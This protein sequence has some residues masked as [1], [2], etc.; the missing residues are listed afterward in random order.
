MKRFY[1]HDSYKPITD[2]YDSYGEHESNE[3]KIMFPERKYKG[4]KWYHVA[5]MFAVLFGILIYGI[6]NPM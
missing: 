3:Y 4:L 6:I 2:E 5:I 1:L